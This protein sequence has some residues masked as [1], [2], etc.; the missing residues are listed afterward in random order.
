MGLNNSP[1]AGGMR[2]KENKAILLKARMANKNR[3][4]TAEERIRRSLSMIGKNVK[5]GNTK[6]NI[7]IRASIESRLWR[8]AVFARDNYTCQKCSKR[9]GRLH[10]HH[11]K[12]FAEYPELR[13]AIDNGQTLCVT[14]HALEHPDIGFF[15]Q[16]GDRGREI[17]EMVR[18]G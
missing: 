6:E 13:F 8:E 10:P 3:V 17:V 14:C 11:M 2:K 12:S 15:K 5:H 4:V 9:G 16:V 7:R 18:N 1:W